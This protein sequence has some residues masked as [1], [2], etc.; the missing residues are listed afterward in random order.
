MPIFLYKIVPVCALVSFLSA[1][2]V[3]V[4]VYF[5]LPPPLAD[6]FSIPCSTQVVDVH[7]RDLR[8]FTSPDGYWRFPARLDGIDPDFIVQLLA[9]EDK[10]FFQHHGVDLLALFRAM[11]QLVTN[12]RVVSGASTITMQTVRLLHPRPRTVWGKLIEMI[13]AL[14]LEQRL[15]KDEIL[16]YYLTLAPYGG[17]IEGI[18]AACRFY[19]D[20]SPARLTPSRAALLI[21]L[22]Q[23]PESRRP[24]LHPL[25]AQQARNKVLRRL[26]LAGLLN[27]EAVQVAC[28]RPIPEKRFPVPFLAPHLS[29]Y[30]FLTNPGQN[31]VRATINRDLQQQ[32]ETIANAVQQQLPTG[33]TLSLLVLENRSRKIRSLV[34]SGGFQ[35]SQIDL[36]RAIRSPG[37][38]LKPFIYGLAF[39]QGI[40]HPETRILDSPQRYGGYGPHNFNEDYQGWVSVREALHRSLNMPAV[41]V[42]NHVGPQR[43]VTR[44]S[45][46]DLTL[47]ADNT[48]GLSLALGGVGT[49]LR[50]L[51]SLYAALAD[52]GAYK[53]LAPVLYALAGTEKP[54]ETSGSD[55]LLSP[56]AAWYVDD[57]LRTMPL[58][59]GLSSGDQSAGKIR[60]KTGTSYGFRDAWAIGYN[61]EYTVGV[62]LGRPD[63]GFG[64]ETTGANSAVPILLQAFAALPQ[65][66]PQPNGPQKMKNEPLPPNVVQ[67]RHE[68]LPPTLQWFGVQSMDATGGYQPDTRPRIYFPVDGTSMQLA[69]STTQFSSLILKAMGGTPPLTWLVNGTPLGREHQEPI[70][71]YVP[72]G[73]GMTTITVVDSNGRRDK[74]SVWLE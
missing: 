41:Q 36:T 3:A 20:T 17:N 64:M 37:S 55:T 70:T 58:P 15:S 51:V 45:R 18:V 9:F 11:G 22:P 57:I 28:N 4:L 60:F 44:F 65:A 49:S 26:A 66:S 46:F 21:S 27:E 38:T 59:P 42:L 35:Y 62:W 68:Q 54:D 23:S 16:E 1:A 14:R 5:F 8:L 10:R 56:A 43:L 39:E 74:V 61:R 2:L 7:G 34:G 71:S 30:L 12:G 13:Q 47:A 53:P 25:R 63:G 31:I 19:F 40:L 73:P 50:E 52:K 33:K 6:D 32:L 24:D 48:P 72:Q 29:R 67:V 69:R